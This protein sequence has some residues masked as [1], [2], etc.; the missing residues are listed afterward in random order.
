ME[1]EKAQIISVG[2]MACL[3]GSYF[4]WFISL[5]HLV[6]WSVRLVKC[7]G[8]PVKCSSKP[9]Q[10]M[11]RLVLHG[12]LK[13]VPFLLREYLTFEIISHC[14]DNI[15]YNWLELCWY[16]D[17]CL[18]LMMATQRY[19]GGLDCQRVYRDTVTSLPNC[20]DAYNSR[21]T[22]FTDL[23]L[24]LCLCNLSL[25]EMWINKILFLLWHC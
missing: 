11:N 25:C 8:W 1:T 18:A 3:I 15:I 6:P 24:L 5:C 19:K 2:R 9:I 23:S 16:Y 4:L 21:L 17:A 14:S 12:A 20:V 7:Q 13:H 10:P 22:Q